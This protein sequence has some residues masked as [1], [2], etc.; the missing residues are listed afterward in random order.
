M[1]KH[2]IIG[3]MS[4]TSLDGVDLAYCEFEETGH[5][6]TFNIGAC[7]TI[8]YTD[9]WLAQLYALPGASALEYAETHTRYGNYLG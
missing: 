3:I 5:S 9:N 7:E 2:C 1:Q 8:G 4:G 6:Y